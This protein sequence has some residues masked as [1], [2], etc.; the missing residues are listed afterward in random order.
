MYLCHC[1]G[2]SADDYDD[3][4]DSLSLKIINAPSKADAI[5]LVFHETH[6]EENGVRRPRCASCIN[7]IEKAI[8]ER[9]LRPASEAPM[10]R[11]DMDKIWLHCMTCEGTCRVNFDYSPLPSA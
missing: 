6:R 8:D 3:A 1:F 2:L 9:G 11:D 4:I 7:Y 5:V 10:T